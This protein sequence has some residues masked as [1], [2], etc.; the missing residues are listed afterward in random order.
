[1][2][3]GRQLGWHSFTSLHTADSKDLLPQTGEPGPKR[4]CALA[5]RPSGDA[6]PGL[7][8]SNREQLSPSTLSQPPF[9]NQDLLHL[10]LS[11]GERSWESL[12]TALLVPA[13]GR[14]TTYLCSHHTPGCPLDEAESC[15]KDL[16]GHSSYC[17]DRP[18][19]CKKAHRL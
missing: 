14:D 19:L 16:T 10:Q 9:K 3:S 17:E 15:C 1:M 2:L 4:I 11:R 8:P 13:Q 6:G 5:P 18:S 7:V 12:S